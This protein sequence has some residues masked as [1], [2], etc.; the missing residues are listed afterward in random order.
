[1]VV[2]CIIRVVVSTRIFCEKMYDHFARPQKSGRRGGYKAGFHCIK[3]Y[4]V[5][6]SRV[7]NLCDFGYKPLTLIHSVLV[8]FKAKMVDCNC[9][10]LDLDDL[11]EK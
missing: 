6:L 11:T 4:V 7:D 5:T 10:A 1:M 2:V 3:F 8:Y 9:K